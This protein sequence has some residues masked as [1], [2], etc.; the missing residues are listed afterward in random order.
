MPLLPRSPP[1]MRG[2]SHLFAKGDRLDWQEKAACGQPHTDP[3][4]WHSE[5]GAA[6]RAVAVCRQ[7]CPVRGECLT[8]A[9]SNDE[10]LG[11]WGGMTTRERDQFSRR[12]SAR[13]DN[14]CMRGHE[15]TVENTYITTVGR[16]TCRTCRTVRKRKTRGVS[17]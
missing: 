14:R 11:V 5:T 15:F 13:L 9:L 8:Y 16:K 12:T 6:R 1:D 3:D 2:L 7:T 17:V 10:R 4:W